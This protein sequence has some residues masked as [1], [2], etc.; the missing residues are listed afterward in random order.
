MIPPRNGV[1]VQTWTKDRV[2]LLRSCSQQAWR[3]K[4]PTGSSNGVLRPASEAVARATKA[5]TG[6]ECQ[7]Q[8]EAT[9]SGRA[10]L[11]GRARGQGE[12]GQRTLCGI[13]CQQ[14]GRASPG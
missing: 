11:R 9:R 6:S 12:A 14:R 1:R 13:A 5:T 3:G 2:L 4:V 8:E 7:A 10:A